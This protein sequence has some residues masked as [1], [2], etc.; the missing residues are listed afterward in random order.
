M[1]IEFACQCGRVLWAQ[2]AWVS[3]PVRCPHC[4]VTLTVPEPTAEEA[5]DTVPPGSAKE[6]TDEDGSEQQ[7]WA[8]ID[9]PDPVAQ[10]A[11]WL[12]ATPIGRL[13]RRAMVSAAALM[14]LA[15]VLLLGRSPA[16]TDGQSGRPT[17]QD[18]TT[19]ASDDGPATSAVPTQAEAESSLSETGSDEAAERPGATSA[20]EEKIRVYELDG[21]VRKSVRLASTGR[22][23]RFLLIPFQDTVSAD[24]SVERMAQEVLK[25]A[26]GNAEELL[27][28]SIACR[29]SL[30][31]QRGR[32][33]QADSSVYV[34]V[35]AAGSLGLLAEGRSVMDFTPGA[36]TGVKELEDR[37][38]RPSCREFWFGQ[39]ADDDRL[40]G[41]VYWWGQVG[42]AT[43]RD[44]SISHIL[45]GRAGGQP[46]KTGR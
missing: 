7:R 42:V 36:I 33:E 25:M 28:S 34:A 27:S 5:G 31:G 2:D 16:P 9:R 10:A 38:G 21:C 26:T 44:G 18:Q 46:T 20:G 22:A 6:C 43:G 32:A 35:F 29:G 15:T 14:L 37:F 11:E 4:G 3:Q 24:E 41:H 39:V 23:V 19:A 17:D 1:A 12:R 40:D 30:D 13:A 45:L 8:G